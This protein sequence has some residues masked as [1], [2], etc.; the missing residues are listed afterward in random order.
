MS[1]AESWLAIGTVVLFGAILIPVALVVS[2]RSQNDG[3]AARLRQV[4]ISLSLYEA[5]HMGRLAPNLLCTR[6]YLGND[7]LYVSP[8]DPWRKT[9]GPFPLDGALPE[10]QNSSPLRI[11]DAYAVDF[12]RAG[13]LKKLDASDLRTTLLADPWQGEASITGRRS[14]DATVS[15]PV[16]R[17]TMDGSAREADRESS[18]LSDA[19]DLFLSLGRPPS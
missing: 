7:S 6:G 5:D 16:L 2:R 13:L 1:R 17:V 14:F 15:G 18:R 12:L 10:A 3:R 11:S 8:K 9:K 4:Y 19:N